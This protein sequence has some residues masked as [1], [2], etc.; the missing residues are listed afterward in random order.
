MGLEGRPP[1]ATATLFTRCLFN[2]QAAKI[3][4]QLG[5]G[6]IC[7]WHGWVPQEK[8][9]GLAQ[10]MFARLGDTALPLKRQRSSNVSV[11]CQV[12]M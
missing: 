8:I 10:A 6:L 2:G 5:S 7:V 3:S 11:V 1:G 12:V 9:M 4:T